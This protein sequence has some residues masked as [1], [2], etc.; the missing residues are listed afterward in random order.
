MSNEVTDK[1]FCDTLYVVL[2]IFYFIFLDLQVID[3]N[4]L[5]LCGKFLDTLTK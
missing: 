4:S 3:E 2:N 5:I 1:A